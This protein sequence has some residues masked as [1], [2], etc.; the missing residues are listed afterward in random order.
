[1]SPAVLDQRLLPCRCLPQSL[2][3][4]QCLRRPVLVAHYAALRWNP[5]A[6]LSGYLRSGQ[7]A[8]DRALT[9]DPYTAHHL[10]LCLQCF[11]WRFGI[12]RKPRCAIQRHMCHWRTRIR[13]SIQFCRCLRRVESTTVKC[14]RL[15]PWSH[16][17]R[18][19]SCRY[20]AVTTQK[21]GR[22]FR[23]LFSEL[24]TSPSFA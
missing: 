5:A 23:C 19:C 21:N 16:V 2:E 20:H 12:R 4:H 10:S 11:A 8:E 15:A 14:S 7:G 24:A 22:R 18:C 13:M 1:M 9:F 3:P 17:W 6:S